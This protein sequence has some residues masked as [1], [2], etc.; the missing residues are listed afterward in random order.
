MT[1]G[2]MWVKLRVHQVNRNSTIKKGSAATVYGYSAVTELNTKGQRNYAYQKAVN[3][4]LAVYRNNHSL[5]SDT[6]VNYNILNDG[7]QYQSKSAKYKT[8]SG[9]KYKGI[10]YKRSRVN[11]KDK[12]AIHKEVNL[13][14]DKTEKKNRIPMQYRSDNPKIRAKVEKDYLEL[15]ERAEKSKSYRKTSSKKKHP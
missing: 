8:K 9:R 6:E 7:I 1:R 13:G 15:Q 3:K 12:R 4:A 5:N 10:S 14:K 11:S 2:S